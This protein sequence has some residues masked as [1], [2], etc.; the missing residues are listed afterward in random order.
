MLFKAAG[1]LR[2]PGWQSFKQI[3]CNVAFSAALHFL[4]LS[5]SLRAADAKLF[6]SVKVNKNITRLGDCRVVLLL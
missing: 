5:T 4:L 6:S 3:K 1:V 2:L